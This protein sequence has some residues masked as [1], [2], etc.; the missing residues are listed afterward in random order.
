MLNQLQ[1]N[2]CTDKKENLPVLGLLL[3]AH[4]LT[5]N[6]LLYSLFYNYLYT[7]STNP[8]RDFSLILCFHSI[9]HVQ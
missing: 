9:V 8:I 4:Q 7:G 2:T 3:A 1:Q 5:Q 6:I